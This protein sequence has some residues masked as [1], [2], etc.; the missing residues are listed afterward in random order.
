MRSGTMVVS[1]SAGQEILG[2]Y[3]IRN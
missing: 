1:Y 2:L 3:G